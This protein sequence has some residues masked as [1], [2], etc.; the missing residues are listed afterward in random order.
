[1]LLNVYFKIF[2]I[3]TVLADCGLSFHLWGGH[4][5]DCDTVG[6]CFGCLNVID[7]FGNQL[8]LKLRPSHLSAGNWAGRGGACIHQRR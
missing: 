1:M 8:R 5:N 2:L 7:F 3:V 4:R 6:V